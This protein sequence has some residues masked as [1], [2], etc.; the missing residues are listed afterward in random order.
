M[1]PFEEVPIGRERKLCKLKEAIHGAGNQDASE[2]GRYWTRVYS[3][4]WGGISV[5]PT[6][7]CP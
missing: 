5:T 4:F 2:T 7:V 1:D 3:W 6:Q